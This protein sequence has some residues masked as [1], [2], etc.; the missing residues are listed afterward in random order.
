MRCSPGEEETKRRCCPW[1][2]RKLKRVN[3]NQV[4]GCP[5]PATGAAWRPPPNDA[6][7]LAHPLRLLSY[8]W[9]TTLSANAKANGK[10]VSLIPGPGQPSLHPG[11]PF[12]KKTFTAIP[13]PGFHLFLFRAAQLKSRDKRMRCI[14]PVDADDDDDDGDEFERARWLWWVAVKHNQGMPVPVC[15]VS[16][17]V[18]AW[19]EPYRM[20]FLAGVRSEHYAASQHC[21]RDISDAAC[22]PACRH[23]YRHT[24]PIHRNGPSTG[25]VKNG[26]LLVA[27]W[28]W[29]VNYVSTRP[30][31]RSCLCSISA[32]FFMIYLIILVQ[33]ARSRRHRRRRILRGTVPGDACQ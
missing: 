21:P 14:I 9:F 32:R 1:S 25:V 7:R 26:M 4:G 33:R 16:Q 6:P 27:G 24:G 20:V 5:W 18:A 23:P 29:C 17:K 15:K 28:R 8:A 2:E 19:N 30:H 11:I 10:C 13:G 12:G 31:P 22:W 3:Q